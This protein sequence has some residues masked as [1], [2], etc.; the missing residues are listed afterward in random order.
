M[1]STTTYHRADVVLVPFP[2][3][4]QRSSQL[5]P[6]LIVSSE[7]YNRATND[8][9]LAMITGNVTAPARPGD[10]MIQNWGGAGL[11]QVSRIRAKLATLHESKIRRPLGTMPAPDLAAFENN[12][13][14]VLQL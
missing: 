11:L 14:Q 13:R 10:H 8:Y 12:L 4:N 3:T 9:I 7:I 1:L 6:A 2:F 5:R